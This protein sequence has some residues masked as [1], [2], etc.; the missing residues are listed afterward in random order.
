MLKI[1]ES[2]LDSWRD[3]IFFSSPELPERFWS[4]LSILFSGYVGLFCVGRGRGRGGLKVSPNESSHK[5][6][7]LLPRLKIKGSLLP[8]AHELSWWAQSQLGL[9]SV[10][11]SLRKLKSEVKLP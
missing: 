10:T 3:T 2:Y 8:Q 1:E 5:H 11:G 6:R 7:H 9:N 4:L